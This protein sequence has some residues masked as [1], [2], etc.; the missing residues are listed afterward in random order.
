MSK[1]I[2]KV[3]IDTNVWVSGLV[4]GGNP[5]DIL[6]QFIKEEIVVIISEEVITE[7]HRIIIQ[8]FSLLK[9]GLKLLEESIR[10]DST[11]V[12]LGDYTVNASRDSDDNK[13]IETAVIGGADYIIS[14]D[15]DLL[16]IVQYKDIKIINPSE[17][18]KL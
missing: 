18:L 14:G 13:I 17:F 16:S 12:H 2:S 8:K 7:L 3:V 11:L 9:P 10:K 1:N 5:R 6:Q 15:E 4:F